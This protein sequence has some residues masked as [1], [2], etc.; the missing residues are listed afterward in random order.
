MSNVLVTVRHHRSPTVPT[1][2]TNNVHLLC[3]E[4]IRGAHDGTDVEIMLEVL[5]SYVK[6]MALA[7]EIRH[8]RV[9][10]Q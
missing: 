3:E 5:D 8:D 1:T 10:F 9:E 7:V 4:C 6:P 2:T